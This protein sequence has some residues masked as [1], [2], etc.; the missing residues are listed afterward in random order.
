MSSQSIDFRDPSDLRAHPKNDEIYSDEAEDWFV[1]NVRENGVLEPVVITSDSHFVD[2]DVEVI[3]SGHRRVDAAEK[4]GLDEIPV[5]FVSYN[6]AADELEALVDFNQQREKN[7]SQKMREALEL[8]AV[9]RSRAKG[10]QGTRTDLD[11]NFGGS[12]WGKSAERVAEMVGFGNRETYR[13]AR[14]VWMLKENGY[15]WAEELVNGLNSGEKSIYRAFKDAEKMEARLQNRERVGWG[16]LEEI[17]PRVA[18]ALVDFFEDKEADIEQRDWPPAIGFLRKEL[19]Q[20]RHPA[21][22]D[23]V[24]GHQDEGWTNVEFGFLYLLEKSGHV[25]LDGEL[26]DTASMEPPSLVDRKPDAD[27]LEEMY[28]EEDMSRREIGIRFSVPWVVVDLWLRDSDVPMKRGHLAPYTQDAIDRL[29][30]DKN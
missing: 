16:E 24:I 5:R 21:Y 9:E 27:L 3:I 17:E 7:F 1:N 26:F 10:R 18:L 12:Q 28:W 4:A 8:E 23:F 6:S 19:K 15:T 30:D 29:R 13:Q 20:S 14:K 25:T 2:D 11:Q 22:W